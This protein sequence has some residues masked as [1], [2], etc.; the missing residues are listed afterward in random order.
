[1]DPA[2]PQAPPVANRTRT[3]VLH[4]AAVILSIAVVWALYR[5]I[6]RDGPAALEAWRNADVHWPLVLLSFALGGAGHL[7]YVVG[8]HRLLHDLAVPVTYW[9]AAR[10]Y[11]V[12]NLG[13]YLPGAKAWQ[14]GIVG[15]MA[16]E[17]QLP[18]TLVA[19]T[20][21]LQGSIGVLVGAILLFATGGAALGIAPAWF[22][23]PIAALAGLLA[24]PALL[25]TLPRVRSLVIK[26]V[27]SVE[28][29]TI[30]TMW[31]LV[32][33]TALS[34]IVLGVALYTLAVALL[35]TPGA[36]IVA[37]TAAWI[38]PFLAG[39]LAIVSPA[40]LGVRDEIMRQMLTTAGVAASGALVVVIVAR[41]WSTVLEV[42]PAVIVLAIR[43]RAPR[44]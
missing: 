34:W 16:A 44:P 22:A 9:H 42:V 18:A 21:L 30:A 14:M 1:M 7:I 28:S 10:M 38:G 43:K 26:R 6:R 4:T 32:W 31:S 11:F 23:A 35:G 29:V 13:R 40:G 39:V 41:I 27:P 15:V 19:A 36:S 17:K 33:T 12:S 20:S 3:I 37:Y 8:W 5:A 25:N 24:A 2:P